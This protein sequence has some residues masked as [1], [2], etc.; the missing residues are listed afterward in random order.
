M[1]DIGREDLKKKKKKQSVK[2]YCTRKWIYQKKSFACSNDKIWKEW[3]YR[4]PGSH[5]HSCLLQTENEKQ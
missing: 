1:R 4:F 2:E 5:Y 3:N